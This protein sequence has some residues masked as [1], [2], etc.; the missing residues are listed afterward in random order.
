MEDTFAVWAIAQIEN[1]VS[2][3]RKNTDIV[4]GVEGE[5]TWLMANPRCEVSFK[6]DNL[7]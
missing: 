3:V 7:S 4:V 6:P 1:P 2:V 5:G